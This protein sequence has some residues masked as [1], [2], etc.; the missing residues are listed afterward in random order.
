MAINPIR[1]AQK[2]NEQFL[3]YQLTASPITDPDLGRQVRETLKGISVSGSPLI[4]GP[5]VSLSKSFLFSDKDLHRLAADEKVHPA[6]PGIASFPTLFA[7]Q[8]ETLT[9]VKEGNTVL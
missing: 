8:A 5:Y 9:A 6:L 4:K 2:V 3:N 1:F 7:H